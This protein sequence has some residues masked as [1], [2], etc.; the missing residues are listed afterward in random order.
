MLI[1]LICA[2]KNPKTTKNTPHEILVL[3]N[4]KIVMAEMN[5][6]IDKNIDGSLSKQSTSKFLFPNKLG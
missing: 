1:V 4:S 5:I 3:V 6:P 2:R